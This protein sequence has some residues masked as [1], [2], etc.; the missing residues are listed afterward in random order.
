MFLCMVTFSNQTC[1]ASARL[2]F[3]NIA[4]VQKVGVCV[5][6]CVCVCMCVCVCVCMCVCVSLPHTLL[7][8]SGMM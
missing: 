1:S 6:V 2:V 8:T 3:L 7:I 5:F 4:F